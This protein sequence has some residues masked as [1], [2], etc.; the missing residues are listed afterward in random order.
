LTIDVIGVYTVENSVGFLFEEGAFGTSGVSLAVGFPNVRETGAKEV[1]VVEEPVG[2]VFQSA[3]IENT[4]SNPKNNQIRN[5]ENLNIHK[6]FFKL[7][8]F[9]IMPFKLICGFPFTAFC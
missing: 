4:V 7:Y 6:R 9:Y 2:T 1:L 5:K 8:I 3:D